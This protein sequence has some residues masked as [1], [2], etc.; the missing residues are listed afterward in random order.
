LGYGTYVFRPDIV[1]GSQVYI[2]DVNAGGGRRLDATR[3]QGSPNQIGAFAIPL[4]LRQGTLGRN[5]IRGFGMY[6]VDVGL[7][8]EFSLHESLKLQFKGEFFN[9][10]NHPSFAEPSGL[11]A[12]VNATGAI[13]AQ[14][15]FGRSQNMLGTSLG[16]GGA[17]GGLSPLYQLGGPR[18]MQLSIKL[19]F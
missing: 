18:S 2:S 13:T 1:Y 10:L 12:V 17:T 16:S 4:E 15:A 5:Q 7:R 6:Q 19:V 3:P 9:I 8:R 14:T 11:L